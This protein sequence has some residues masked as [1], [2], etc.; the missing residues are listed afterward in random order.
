VVRL[1]PVPSSLLEKLVLDAVR[2]GVA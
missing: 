2:D 1:S